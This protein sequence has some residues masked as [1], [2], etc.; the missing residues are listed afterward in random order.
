M[1]VAV[2]SD[3]HANLP[4]LETFVEATRGTVDSYL[5]LGDVVD[6]GPW[7]DEC[8]DLIGSLPGIVLLEGNHERLFRGEETIDD[9]PDLAKLFFHASRRSFTRRSALENLP[10]SVSVGQFRAEHTLAGLRLYSNTAIEITGK[11]FVGHSHYAFRRDFPGGGI[12]VNCGSVGQNRHRIDQI[13]YALYDPAS[14]EIRLEEKP[15][16]LDRFVTELVHRNYPL[17]CIDYYRRKRA[18]L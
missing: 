17:P 11:H 14:G 3:V 12:L 8:L 5:C 6:Y 13:S 7:N 1:T 15:Y 4:A 9:K 2:F 10:L 18:D 16:P